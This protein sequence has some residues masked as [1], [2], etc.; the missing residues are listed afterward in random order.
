MS[1][2]NQSEEQAAATAT[3]AIERVFGADNRARL[4]QALL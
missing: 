3:E 2:A 1:T 4:L